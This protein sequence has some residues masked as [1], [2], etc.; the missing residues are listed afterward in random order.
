[1]EEY[2]NPLLVVWEH[3]LHNRSLSPFPLSFLFAFSL[4]TSHLLH[5]FFFLF[6][7]ANLRSLSRQIEKRAH[8]VRSK[9]ITRASL[10]SYNKTS[11]Q[12]SQSPLIGVI[13]KISSSVFFPSGTSA[14]PERSRESVI[15]SFLSF[16]TM[17]KGS[18]CSPSPR[19]SLI[20]SHIRQR[21]RLKRQREPTKPRTTRIFSPSSSASGVVQE[22]SPATVS[23]PA[24]LKLRL[25]PRR[26]EVKV[27]LR[28]DNLNPLLRLTLGREKTIA[29]VVKHLKSKWAASQTFL[30]SLGDV[31]W[32]LYPS[33]SLTGE[34]YGTSPYFP[35]YSLPPPPPP[36]ILVFRF[37][38][39]Q[40]K[41]APWQS[42]LSTISSVSRKNSLSTT[43]FFHLF[44]PSPF[45]GPSPSPFL[46]SILHVLMISPC[47][48]LDL[49][50][51]L[52]TTPVFITSLF[53]VTVTSQSK[54]TKFT[55]KQWPSA[56]I[57]VFPFI[58]LSS[59]ST[60]HS[61]S[62]HS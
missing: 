14:A 22:L 50:F 23:L 56:L 51:L 33:S 30:P 13:P 44:D 54:S 37:S 21:S 39:L 11:P 4:Q 9:N 49:S 58:Y 29:S 15:A 1:M 6:S 25:R 46:S 34:G 5:R 7:R 45:S 59:V 61:F 35:F 42:R 3:E 8:S 27:L 53:P 36:P 41:I 60:D 52:S 43:T 40:T 20:H 2:G 19:F 31:E 48:F 18:D 17:F 32:K 10:I 26:E 24:K 38:Y 62:S 55:E 12:S 47:S 28:K 57:V 16:A